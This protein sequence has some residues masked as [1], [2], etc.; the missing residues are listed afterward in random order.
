MGL[1]D[2]FKEK[3]EGLVQDAK[4]KVSEATGVDADKLIDTASSL[5]DAGESLSDAADSLREG[6]EKLAG[7]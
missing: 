3:A 7:S 2:K 5:E 1:L 6:R 4:D